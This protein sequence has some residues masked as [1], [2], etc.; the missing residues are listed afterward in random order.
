MDELLS[1]PQQAAAAEPHH[2]GT[3]TPTGIDAILAAVEAFDSARVNDEL[4]RLAALLTPAEF[5]YQVAMPLMRTV[6]DRWH[7]GTLQAAQEHL[8]TESI[9]QSAGNHG[10]AESA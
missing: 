2:T 6:G 9:A 8:V 3:G 10:A 7:E 4:G 5:V 1:L